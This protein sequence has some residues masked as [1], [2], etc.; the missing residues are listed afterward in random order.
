MQYNTLR[1]FEEMVS[2]VA[3][4]QNEAIDHLLRLSLLEVL[5]VHLVFL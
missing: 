1:Y 3:L 2:A 5:R 4:P